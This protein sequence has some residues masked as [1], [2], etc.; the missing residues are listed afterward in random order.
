MKKFLKNTSGNVM[1]ATALLMVPLMLS[2]GAAV[3]YSQL[4]R[5]KTKLQS[6]V[7][8]AALAVAR[9]LQTSTQGEIELKVENF[10]KINLSEEQ[11]SE[12]ADFSVKI[13]NAKQRVTVTVNS[14]HPATLM[15]IAGINTFSYSPSSTVGAPT[16]NIEIMLVLDTTGSMQGNKIVELRASATN[17]VTELLELNTTPEKVKIGIVPFSNYVN[18]GTN[19]RNADWINVPP[20][21]GTNVWNGCVGSRTASRNLTDSDYSFKVPGVLGN[22]TTPITELTSD[23]SILLNEIEELSP[24]GRTFI[25][26]GLIWGQRSLSSVEPF[27]NGSNSPRTQKAIVLMTDGDNTIS[28]GPDNLRLHGRTILSGQS[29]EIIQQNLD[30][31]SEAKERADVITEN[32][33]DNMKQEGIQ[34]YTIGFGNGISDSTLRLLTECSSESDNYFVAADGEQLNQAFV[35]IGQQISGIILS[36]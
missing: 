14:S 9:D 29:D 19:N 22:C 4:A 18:V 32:I 5:K 30:F 7:D 11:Y 10:L 6:V 15:R 24:N 28:V 27:T 2:A 36:N 31:R 23:E 26:P 20:N 17:F 3:D 21:D 25:A 35:T 8:S 33:C 12:I 16:V 34:I 13:P 1:I